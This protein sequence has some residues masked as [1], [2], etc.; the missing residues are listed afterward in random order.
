MAYY[1]PYF[2]G[3]QSWQAVPFSPGGQGLMTFPQFVPRLPNARNPMSLYS[4]NDPGMGSIGRGRLTF[5][6]G[7]PGMGHVRQGGQGEMSYPQ[8]VQGMVPP[9]Q[10]SHGMVYYY[11]AAP[12][13]ASRTQA[14]QGLMQQSQA[15][16]EMES[17]T[18]SSLGMMNY[19][20]PGLVD[21]GTASY[22]SSGAFSNLSLQSSETY[23]PPQMSML[24]SVQLGVPT[25]VVHTEGNP[26]S[27]QLQL[28]NEYLIKSIQS[29][30]STVSQNP[31]FPSVYAPSGPPQVV[32]LCYLNYNVNFCDFYFKIVLK[33]GFDFF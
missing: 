21:D 4:Q 18:Q 13:N 28:C 20:V 8:A 15:A 5:T 2:F 31:N 26:L 3:Q 7:A 12:K 10:P 29:K 25:E 14:S 11:Q 17:P 23:L 1:N 9:T 24:G 6:P 33:C 22:F 19:S 30:L 32:K 27:M 16:P